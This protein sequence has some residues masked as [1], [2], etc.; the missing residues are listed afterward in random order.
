MYNNTSPI[1]FP[2]NFLWGGFCKA[3][4]VFLCGKMGGVRWGGSHQRLPPGGKLSPQATDEGK[5]SGPHDLPGE[6][7]S[8]RAIGRPMNK[9]A[10]SRKTQRLSGC[11]SVIA[12][13]AGLPAVGAAPR[14]R[15]IRPA[16]RSVLP[17]ASVPAGHGRLYRARRT[18]ARFRRSSRC[19]TSRWETVP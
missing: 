3:A 13:A 17:R 15:C 4:P 9:Q 18:A 14:C 6:R 5:S 10:N 1:K 12:A 11:L 2:E 7:G 19:P 8:A 16:V